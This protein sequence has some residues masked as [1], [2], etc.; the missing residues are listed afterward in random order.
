MHSL[1]EISKVKKSHCAILPDMFFWHTNRIYLLSEKFEKVWCAGR[2]AQVSVRKWYLLHPKCW[3]ERQEKKMSSG[4]KR[5][6]SLKSVN[7]YLKSEQ[8][9]NFKTWNWD[10]QSWRMKIAL[11]NAWQRN[12]ET[13]NEQVGQ[14]FCR[15][16]VQNGR[17][18]SASV[19]FQI[20]VL[21]SNS[22]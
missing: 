6:I 20:G 15:V 10:R 11:K 22:F 16:D 18:S 19:L 2:D 8:N 4:Q 5:S 14:F 3:S 7:W 13:T 21:E 1:Q 17:C 12:A 9:L